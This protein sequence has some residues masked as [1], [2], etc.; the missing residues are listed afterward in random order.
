MYV[1]ESAPLESALGDPALCLPEPEAA[2]DVVA[3]LLVRVA[4][5]TDILSVQLS[6]G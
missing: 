1:G 4:M 2:P 6:A 5:A 3:V